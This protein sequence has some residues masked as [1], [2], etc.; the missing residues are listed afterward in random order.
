[1]AK[2]KRRPDWQNPQCF[3]RGK[4]SAHFLQDHFNTVEEAAQGQ[5]SSWKRSLNGNWKFFWVKGA[6]NRL[7]YVEKQEILSWKTI[8]V[9]SCRQLLG[10]GKPYYL[11]FDYPPPV[12]KRKH[13]IPHIK[14]NQNEIAYYGTFFTVPDEWYDQTVY[15]RLNA[16][17]SACYIYL[18]G[19]EIG[20]SQGSMLPAEFDLTPHLLSGEN[21]LLVEVFRYSDGTYLEDQDMWFF[22]GIYRDVELI[23]EPKTHIHD[24]YLRSELQENYSSALLHVTAEIDS[25]SATSRP[26][27]LRFTLK[28]DQGAIVAEGHGENHLIKGWTKYTLGTEL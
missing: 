15:L 3:Q 6:A 22:S 4:L 7:S 17:K 16:V 19:R 11:A 13:H 21:T 2:F 8:P 25:V 1:M 5:A 23:A 10:H 27:T 20:Y 26:V 18:N 14:D 24:M 9:P 12:D 28:D